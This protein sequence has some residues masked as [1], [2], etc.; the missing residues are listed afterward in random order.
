MV[1]VCR[2]GRVSEQRRDVLIDREARDRQKHESVVLL[3][4]LLVFKIVDPTVL[5]LNL[6]LSTET[7]NVQEE[8]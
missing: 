1:A 7:V 8:L 6:K 4:V 5:E 2:V 3:P